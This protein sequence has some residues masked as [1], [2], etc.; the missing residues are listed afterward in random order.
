[1]APSIVSARQ[2]GLS[3]ELLESRSSTSGAKTTSTTRKTIADSTV[4]PVAFG[5]QPKPLALETSSVSNAVK[6]FGQSGMSSDGKQ[7][8]LA[9]AWKMRRSTLASV[10]DSASQFGRSAT[11][12]AV[13]RYGWSMKTVVPVATRQLRADRRFRPI[14]SSHPRH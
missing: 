3:V 13:H 10:P 7:C 11:A 12:A 4:K 8:H 9:D 5:H 14:T 6:C 2:M 1:M